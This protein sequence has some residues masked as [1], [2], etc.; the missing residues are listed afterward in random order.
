MEG[1]EAFDTAN[2][3]SWNKDYIKNSP[4]WPY[5]GNSLEIWKC[6]ADD[7]T[8]TFSGFTLP[9]IRTMSMNYWLGGAGGKPYTSGIPFSDTNP[10][11]TPL[12]TI[13]HKFS[14]IQGKGGVTSIFVFLDMRKDS[15][16]NGNFGTCMDGYPG[17]SSK[18]QFWDLPGMAHSRGCSFSYADGHAEGHKWTDSRTT[19]P[20]YT[21]ANTQPPTSWTIFTSSGNQDI[22]W[23]QDHATRP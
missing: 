5:C 18:Y 6:P 23:L 12:G 11:G 1:L 14:E 17:N 10:D 15:V 7:S 20:Y 2:Q 21:P 9:R 3:A 22:G 16:N 4:L 8:A 13:Y 19:K